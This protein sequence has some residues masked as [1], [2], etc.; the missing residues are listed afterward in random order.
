MKKITT[1]DLIRIKQD[2]S[3][4]YMEVFSKLPDVYIVSNVKDFSENRRLIDER[5]STLMMSSVFLSPSLKEDGEITKYIM[6]DGEECFEFDIYDKTDNDKVLWPDINTP[7]IKR[8]MIKSYLNKERKIDG[9]MLCYDSLYDNPF[10]M[11]IMDNS[12]R[13]G[14]EEIINDIWNI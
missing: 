8:L 14:I 9:L 2:V 13:K 3:S 1:D 6:E 10:V 11:N 7:Q 5:Y 12:Y 4:K